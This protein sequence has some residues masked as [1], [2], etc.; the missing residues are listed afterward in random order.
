MRKS[1]I[2]RIKNQNFALKG[3]F[4]LR[5]VEKIANFGFLSVPKGH[6]FLFALAKLKYEGQKF[7]IMR[8]RR[9]FVSF[10]APKEKVKTDKKLQLKY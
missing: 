4:L 6:L 2:I 7:K 3:F 5:T 1:L 10:G 9:S 8:F